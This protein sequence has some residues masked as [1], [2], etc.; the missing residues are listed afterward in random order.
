MRTTLAAV[1]FVAI[2]AL[3]GFIV[4]PVVQGQ[5][6]GLSAFVAICRSLGL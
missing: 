4:L 2:P 1:L 6:A 3:L 5:S